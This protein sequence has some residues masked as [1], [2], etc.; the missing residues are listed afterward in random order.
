MITKEI[1]DFLHNL[2]DIAGQI[3]K[4]YFRQKINSQ[5]KDDNSP[6]T[7]ADQE[8]EKTLREN[9]K[10]R[11]PSHGIIGEEFGEANSNA[12]FIWVIDPIDGTK[13]FMAGFPTFTN[14]ISLCYKKK[15]ILG[16]INQPILNERWIGYEEKA[17]FN[18]KKISTR[19]CQNINEAEIAS[20][21][22][23]YFSKEKLS[24][25]KNIQHQTKFGD[26]HLY[27]GD[28]YLFAM[29]ASGNIDVIIESGLKKYDIMAL[30]PI[31][32]GAGGKIIN[33]NK[34][35]IDLESKGD[36]IAFGNKKLLS[37]IS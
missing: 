23:A 13:A 7:I 21:S 27:G 26:K 6:V 19:K 10:N 16:I 8:I 36:V 29:L 18:G 2:A 30:A 22:L 11:F 33:W 15:P 3:S 25:L 28:A 9:I 32:I 31:I 4:K 20:T 5:L 34:S 24:F 37:L 35:E 17:F 14:L 12:D 1:I